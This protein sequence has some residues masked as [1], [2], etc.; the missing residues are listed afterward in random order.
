[1]RNTRSNLALVDLGSTLFEWWDAGTQYRVDYSA[2]SFRKVASFDPQ[3][4]TWD[5]I[6]PPEVIDVTAA[7]GYLHMHSSSLGGPV[8]YADGALNITFVQQSFVNG[9]DDLFTG[10]VGGNVEL[11]GLVDCLGSELTGSEVESGTIF[12]PNASSPAAPHKYRMNVDTLTMELDVNGDGSLYETVGLATGQFPMS[13]PYTWGMQSGPMVTDLTGIQNVQD[14][15]EAAEFF[16]YETGHNE[17]NQYTAIKDA[18][19]VTVAFD[20][21]IEF[22]YEHSTAADLN[23]SSDY[24]G[25]S[26]LLQYGGTGDL[27]GFPHEQVDLNGDGNPDVYQPLV[28]IKAGV[29]MGPTGVEYILRPIRVEQTL[30]LDPGAAPGLNLADADSLVLPEISEFVTPTNGEDPDVQAPPAVIN[31]VVNGTN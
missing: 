8:S 31:G 29:V 6:T 7:G 19:D 11:L 14:I 4:E 27:H 1:M 20:A 23:D 12:L 30:T 16:T 17:W 18:N 26:F 9:A 15:Y 21:P 5:D 24:D 22:L 10:A 28:N 25:D 3:N 2:G 13:G